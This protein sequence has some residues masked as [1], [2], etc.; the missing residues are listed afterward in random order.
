MICYWHGRAVSENQ[1]L[2]PGRGRWRP[3]PEY[4]GFLESVAWAC[5]MHFEY[6]EGPVSVR[7]SMDLNPRMDALNVIKPVIDALE[8]AGVF[9]NDK[10]VRSFSLYREDR[11]PKEDDRIGITVQDLKV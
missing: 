10:Q 4:K 2:L 8:L 5:K 1:R 9:K 7:L 3:N 6:F 11:G